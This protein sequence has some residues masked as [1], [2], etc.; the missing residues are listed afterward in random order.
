MLREYQSSRY[1]DYSN[2]KDLQK[3]KIVMWQHKYYL[4]IVLISNFGVTGFLGWLNGDILGMMLLAGFTRLILVHH[5]TFFINSLAHMWGSRPF[6][7]K[8]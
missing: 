1:T 5:V 8:N 3:D 4:P 7:D 6:T 2:C